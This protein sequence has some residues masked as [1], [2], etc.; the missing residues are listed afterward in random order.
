MGISGRRVLRLWP[1]TSSRRFSRG[2]FPVTLAGFIDG[3]DHSNLDAHRQ[4]NYRVLRASGSPVVW[5]TKTV[6]PNV[7]GR[8]TWK[9]TEAASTARFYRVLEE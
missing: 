3:E 5:D 9:D 2:V 7:V 8:V 4:G 6:L 1:Q